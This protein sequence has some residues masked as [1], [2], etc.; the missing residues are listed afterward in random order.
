[1]RRPTGGDFWALVLAGEDVRGRRSA[2]PLPGRVGAGAAPAPAASALAATLRRVVPLAGAART[3]VALPVGDVPRGCGELLSIPARN[4]FRQPRASRAVA[5]CSALL[6]VYAL[7][8]GARVATFAGEHEVE[9]DETFRAY[10]RTAR[11]I[12][13]RHPDAVVMMGS[14][15]RRPA[16]GCCYVEPGPRAPRCAFAPAFTVRGFHQPCDAEAARY[17]VARGVLCASSV[18]VARVER[19][20]ELLEAAG[21]AEIERRAYFV[22]RPKLH[23]VVLREVLRS[24][25]ERTLLTQAREHAVV[26]RADGLERRG[27]GARDVAASARPQDR[28]W[29]LPR[30]TA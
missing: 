11:W 14:R 9:N 15:P 1:M 2:R 23:G 13:K 22:R 25:V 7:D 30:A 17:L 24:G 18:L 26:L 16:P 4:V 29:H 6:R 27:P 3:A 8:A 12:V 5:L 10:V 19:L 21:S 20:L 28:S